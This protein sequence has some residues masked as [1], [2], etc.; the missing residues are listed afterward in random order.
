MC[1]HIDPDRLPSSQYL[2]IGVHKPWRR[3]LCGKYEYQAYKKEKAGEE[4]E[5]KTH[6]SN[7]ASVFLIFLAFRF[8]TLVHPLASVARS[9]DTEAVSEME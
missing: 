1:T 3:R 7:F 6:T 5:I 4:E 9:S 2:T 8:S